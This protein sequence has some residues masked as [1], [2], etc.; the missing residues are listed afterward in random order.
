MSFKRFLIWSSDRPPVRLSKTIYA[1]LKD[2][3]M[4]NY[5]VKL[6]EIWTSGSG[7]DVALTV[8]LL[9]ELEPFA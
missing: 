1:F 9:S 3:I 8:Q 4:G 7:G 2:G 5:H 6:Y